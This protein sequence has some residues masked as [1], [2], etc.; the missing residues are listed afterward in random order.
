WIKDRFAFD[1]LDIDSIINS[2][3]RTKILREVTLEEMTSSTIFLISDIF[4]CRVPPRRALIKAK[5][6][7]V[8]DASTLSNYLDHVRTFFEK[9]SPSPEDQ[10][11]ILG[12]MTDM[13]CYSIIN[14]LREGPLV[15]SSSE[16]QQ[17]K[18]E[19]ENFDDVLKY[20]FEKQI[21]SV[22]KSKKNEEVLFLLS[23]VSVR[24][25][26]PEYLIDQIRQNYYDGSKTDS[27]LLEHLRIQNF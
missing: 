13:N 24:L 14:Q 10:D 7:S 19:I 9:Y 1:Y 21:I 16:Y 15:S 2:M 12:I 27:V 22:Q 5:G 8:V 23:D 18:A 3:L 6:K 25:V 4:A 20:L 11:E 17:L 26:F